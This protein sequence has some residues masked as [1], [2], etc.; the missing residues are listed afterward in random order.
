MPVTIAVW[1]WP[2][3]G[4]MPSTPTLK[5]EVSGFGYNYQ[6]TEGYNG[7]GNSG[8]TTICGN[9]PNSGGG[10]DGGV[11]QIVNDGLLM[12]KD[13]RY[14]NG[15]GSNIYPE[16]GSFATYVSVAGPNMNGTG[17]HG[18]TVAPILS[19][20]KQVTQSLHYATTTSSAIW[21]NWQ[22][23]FDTQG[24]GTA[25]QLPLYFYLCDEP[26]NGCTWANL[27]SNGNTYHGYLNPGVP[28]LVTTDYLSA[29]T[30]NA[31]NAI[32]IMVVP[33]STLE[34]VGGPIQ[35]LSNYTTWLNTTNPSGTVRQFWS[36]LSCSVSG[37]CTNGTSG[38]ST[39]TFPNYDVDG[40]PAA[41]R[42]MEWMTYLHGQTGE[43]Y[44]AADVCEGWNVYP[45]NTCGY[46]AHPLD[47]W[48]SNYYS[49][50]WGDGTL[51]YTGGIVSGKP[52]YMGSGVTI[53][54]ILP[55][56]RLKIIRDGVQD[57][58]YLYKLNSLGYGTFVNA[59]LKSWVTNSYT[60]ETTGS[61]LQSARQA[62]GNQMHA[63][64]YGSSSN[65][66]TQL[67]PGL[68]IKVK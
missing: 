22:S 13:H 35:S 9:Y 1:Q 64:T 15:G 41:N 14:H 45:P 49:G 60:F 21:T 32:D 40:K 59:Q 56:L 55:S 42:A 30:N 66:S 19:G 58:E 12:M 18:G 31:L 4:Y 34:P 24:W 50:G 8:A 33:I 48:V 25:G 62:L 27:V 17:T 68:A 23:N 37:T 5:T 11:T 39:S 10:N 46:P 67:P 53:P 54:I 20:A 51:T 57:Y 44:Y 26:P 36:Y 38:G 52:S 28:N 6:C 65:P 43:L 3:A 61:G 16:A 2:N 29:K 47:P 63:L 7:D